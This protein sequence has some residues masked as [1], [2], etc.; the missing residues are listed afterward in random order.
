MGSKYVI[1]GDAGN[2]GDNA[3]I[4][5]IKVGGK[6]GDVFAPTEFASKVT[7]LLAAVKKH[8]DA[9]NKAA[10]VAMVEKA[11]Q[12]A[13]QGDAAGA[14]ATLKKAGAWVFDVARDIGVNIAAA[15]IRQQ[16]GLP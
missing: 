13:S 11:E 4:G 3:K 16:S 6:G 15:I 10:D 5:S 12:Q 7:D 2:V 1:K 14:L 8:P 9:Q